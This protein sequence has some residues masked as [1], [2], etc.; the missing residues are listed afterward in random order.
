MYRSRVSA[1]LTIVLSGAI[2]FFAVLECVLPVSA[3]A[4][5]KVW[6]SAEWWGRE[7][8]YRVVVK[9]VESP[10]G[11]TMEA[12]KV[13]LSQESDLCR[14]G[15]EDIRVVA[16]DGAALAHDVSRGDG[17]EL[18]VIFHASPGNQYYRIYFGNPGADS[19]GDYT[20]ETTETGGLLLETRPL[21]ERIYR[22]GAIADVMGSISEIYGEGP[23]RR[24]NDTSNP[25][26]LNRN[27]LATYSG[28][29]Y[30]SED[31]E[32]T[33]AVKARDAAIF[34]LFDQGEKILECRQDSAMLGDGWEIP[35]QP[36]AKQSVHLESGWY[37]VRYH[38]A[39]N[40]APHLAKL[41]WQKPSSKAIAL[42]PQDAFPRYRPSKTVARETR[43]EELNPYF[44]AEQLYDIE[45][46]PGNTVFH[47]F[48]LTAGD[49]IC[50]RGR[51]LT[52]EW[53]FGDGEHIKGKQVRH[54][55]PYKKEFDLSLRVSEPDGKSAKRT[56]TIQT[57]ESAVAELGMDMKVQP[58]NGFPVLEKE[59]TLSFELSFC[60]NSDLNRQFSYRIVR[61]NLHGE[62][63]N[64]SPDREIDG[65]KPA[66]EGGGWVNITEHL[67][68]PHE[69]VRLSFQLLFHGHPVQEKRFSLI[70][71]PGDAE[72]LRLDAPNKLVDA[73]GDP[74][75][76]VLSGL[77]LN[78][79]EHR[80]YGRFNNGT[81]RMLVLDSL[82][83]HSV[84]ANTYLDILK[85]RLE[86]VYKP[87]EFDITVLDFPSPPP[88]EVFFTAVEAIDKYNPD[89]LMLA[90]FLGDTTDVPQPGDFEL[91]LAATIEQILSRTDTGL[92]MVTPP[93]FPGRLHSARTFAE[94]I[95][96]T[97]FTKNIA[98]ADPYSRFMLLDDRHSCFGDRNGDQFRGGEF[99]LNEKAQ[100]LIAEEVLAAIVR[101]INVE[102]HD[103]V[104]RAY[105]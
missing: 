34:Q 96:R 67:P 38:H 45:I 25:F 91:S 57:N 21:P 100:N 102:L 39:A 49:Y 71:A 82:R 87:L 31:G 54:E 56:R 29:L 8:Q 33:F 74:A 9:A 2:A 42:V 84:E 28:M 30:A 73:K 7:W 94:I 88:L 36:D 3:L 97:G 5:D 14:P 78:E 101:H 41:G 105:F 63:V 19:S 85:A 55:L 98:V 58:A 80:R 18:Y 62:R 103:A 76:L 17:G 69:D 46:K 52:Y 16:P 15:G 72:E 20:Y 22:A 68:G 32:Y 24:I 53:I 83:K 47:S 89:M 11:A 79:A 4:N 92:I 35:G 60:N 90:G 70:Q 44:E 37:E 10:P 6:E 40:S 75:L 43:D 13:D 12:V 26:G 61:E 95:K 65:L 50:T 27:Y 99:L 104:R 51:D 48:R 66:S 77:A 81:I 23:R 59:Q 86:K 64:I 1:G 93:P